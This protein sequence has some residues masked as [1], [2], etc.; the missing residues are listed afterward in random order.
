MTHSVPTPDLNTFVTQITAYASLDALIASGAIPTL[1]SFYELQKRGVQLALDETIAAV[2]AGIVRRGLHE[3]GIA[4]YPPISDDE[5]V[6]W[7]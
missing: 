6:T 2:K 3:R 7:P 5:R 1:Y 4:V